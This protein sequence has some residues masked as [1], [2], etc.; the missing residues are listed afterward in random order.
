MAGNETSPVRILL[1]WRIGFWGIS[2][3]LVLLGFVVAMYVLDQ[4][5]AQT[6]RVFP[7]G[8]VGLAKAVAL[9]LHVNTIWIWIVPVAS[10][11][12]L[13]WLCGSLAHGHQSSR[14]SL[15]FP[16]AVVGI[17]ASHVF[18]EVYLAHCVTVRTPGMTY[19]FGPDSPGSLMAFSIT[20]L[21]LGIPAGLVLVTQ[22]IRPTRS[23]TGVCRKCGYDL[24][25]SKDRC[26][27]CGTAI[28]ARRASCDR[29]V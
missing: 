8:A 22:L 1:V 28:P 3:H 23:K 2:V 24:R 11:L 14:F 19:G 26:P 6:L 17:L 29:K 18:A 7:L 27:E 16:L 25:A 21:W 20:D 10:D 4:A 5:D 9:W 15:F 13:I 12:V